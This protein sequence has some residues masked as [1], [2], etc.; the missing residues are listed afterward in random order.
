MFGCF[1]SFVACE[2]LFISS[3]YFGFDT[4]FTLCFIVFFFSIFLPRLKAGCMRV[5]HD[6]MPRSTGVAQGKASDERGKN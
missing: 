5:D 4:E 2:K 3:F 6:V 1:N